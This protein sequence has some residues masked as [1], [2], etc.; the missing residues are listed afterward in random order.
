MQDF[1]AINKVSPRTQFIFPPF[2][3]SCPS[4]YP[5]A[6]SIRVYSDFT[7]IRSIIVV[8]C[9]RYRARA[10]NTAAPLLNYI[11]YCNCLHICRYNVVPSYDIL[12]TTRLSILSK[13]YVRCREREPLNHRTATATATALEVFRMS[14]N[15]CKGTDYISIMQTFLQKIFN[16]L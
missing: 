13:N 9:Y 14:M 16:F 3:S 5:L 12:R 6:C 7:R 2:V 4:S 15:F 8:T 11:G 1:Q 10:T